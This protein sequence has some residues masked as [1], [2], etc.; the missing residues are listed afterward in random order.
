METLEAPNPQTK[1]ENVTV[2]EHPLDADVRDSQ[3]SLLS[4][5]TSVTDSSNY[6]SRLSLLETAVFGNVSASQEK[7]TKQNSTSLSELVSR[8]QK[9]EEAVNDNNGSSLYTETIAQTRELILNEG[10]SSEAAELKDDECTLIWKAIKAE[11][12]ARLSLLEKFQV[13]ESKLNS[14]RT[15]S[16]ARQM[17]TIAACNNGTSSNGSRPTSVESDDS[18]KVNK[19]SSVK[20]LISADWNNRLAQ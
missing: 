7:L 4:A 2:L 1:A 8:M 19:A 6:Q 3:T 15:S 5:C 20:V 11:A 10:K 13:L 12:T 18:G 16:G 14:V 9:I 17:C